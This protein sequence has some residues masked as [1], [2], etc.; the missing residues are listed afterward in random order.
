MPS[1]ARADCDGNSFSGNNA[2]VTRTCFLL[3]VYFSD[4]YCIFLVGYKYRFA[5]LPLVCHSRNGAAYK[6][7][8]L[9]WRGKHILDAQITSL[10][11]D[12]GLI[13]AYVQF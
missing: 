6:N 7:L 5:L 8:T 9:H 10:L 2:T 4:D 13:K 12:R 1:H 3:N 11:N